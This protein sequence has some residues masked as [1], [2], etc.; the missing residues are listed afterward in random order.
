[1]RLVNA[2]HLPPLHV[3]DGHVHELPRGG[4]A[5]GLTD[6]ATY[7]EQQ[8]TLAPGDLLVIYSD[9]LTEAR[10]EDDAFFGDE[11]LHAYLGR[12]H[13][14]P[15]DILGEMLLRAVD[16]FAGEAPTSDDLSLILLRRTG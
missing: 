3:H 1:M 6:A 4:A 7:A 15:I 8:V 16:R 9:G 12:L 10:D 14:R 13:D 2:G 5:L 11:R